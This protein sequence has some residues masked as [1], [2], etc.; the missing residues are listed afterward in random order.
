MLTG[1]KIWIQSL[2]KDLS[3]SFPRFLVAA[4]E[5]LS[6]PRYFFHYWEPK[7]W[8]QHARPPVRLPWFRCVPTISDWSTRLHSTRARCPCRSL[9]PSFVPSNTHG[10][11]TLNLLAR[12]PSTEGCMID[13]SPFDGLTLMCLVLRVRMAHRLTRP[14]AVLL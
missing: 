5:N 14:W 12:D 13:H 8:I 1:I 9:F 11:Q 6:D 10:T 2:F 4:G 7:P 3:E